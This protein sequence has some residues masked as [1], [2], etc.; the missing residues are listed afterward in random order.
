M[1]SNWEESFFQGI[2]LESWRRCFT[3]ETTHAEA[4]FLERQMKL[5][6]GACLLDMACGNGRHA[7]QLAARGYRV[8]GL[9]Q[10]QEFLAEAR[11]NP[12]DVHWVLG[13]MR[14][15]AFAAE[16][17]A[18][19]CFGNSFGYLDGDEV[20]VVLAGVAR[21]LRPGGRFAID[22]GMTAE[23]IL[24]N[25]VRNRWF[26]LGDILM[27]SRNWYHS[28]ESRL[29]IEYTFVRGGETVTR[30]TSSYVFTAAELCRMHRQAGLEPVAL[31][32][33]L[34]GEPYQLGSPRLIL[35]SRAAG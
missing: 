25:L 11:G 15:L 35:V 3:A 32:G 29:E 8:T 23:S 9:D 34:E 28:A 20:P 2:A 30:P 24:P 1:H 6:P 16:F 19:W 18:A 7:L 27:L 12:A 31:L 26:Q 33:S 14:E 22:T 13:D 10:S 4:D 21:A 17:D 5:Q